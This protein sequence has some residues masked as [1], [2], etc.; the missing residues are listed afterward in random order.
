MDFLGSAAFSRAVQAL[1]IKTGQLVCLKI[2]KV[3]TCCNAGARRP[4]TRPVP[5]RAAAVRMCWRASAF[6]DAASGD[7]A[8]PHT[9]THLHA[10]RDAATLA[11]MCCL[12]APSFSMNG[13]RPQNHKDYFD[14]SLDE[15][16]LLKYVNTMDPNDE[17][18][19]VR[20]YDFFYYKV[21]NDRPPGG[22]GARRW[23]G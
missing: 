18:A 19:I 10:L 15:I 23:W 13:C 17:Y 6:A 9:F 11:L 22:G 14:Q 4:P 21:R 20:L 8:G 5:R 2:I 12:P 7:A 1:D 16:K 3:R